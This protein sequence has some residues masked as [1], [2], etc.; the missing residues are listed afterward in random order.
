[1]S[2]ARDPHAPVRS[3][4]LRSNV[5]SRRTRHTAPHTPTRL[6]VR[7]V[8]RNENFAC[9]LNVHVKFFLADMVP[10][11]LLLVGSTA[12][13]FSPAPLRASKSVAALN[14]HRHTAPRMAEEPQTASAADKA[15]ATAAP[16]PTAKF[17]LK[18]IAKEEAKKGA[19][20]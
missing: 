4:F 1:V 20:L 2:A 11:A 13:L 10:F 16:A 5:D 15:A 6:V 18:S 3:A 14:G 7:V 17:D 8:C 9:E 12:L 19:G